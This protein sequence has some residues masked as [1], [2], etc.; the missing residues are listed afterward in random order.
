MEKS[1]QSLSQALGTSWLFAEGGSPEL[2]HSAF[3]SFHYEQ[4]CLRTFRTQKG[5]A[6]RSVVGRSQEQLFCLSQSPSANSSFFLA[7]ICMATDHGRDP[8]ESQPFTLPLGLIF[9]YASKQSSC[10]GHSGTS[11]K[12]LL[13]VRWLEKGCLALKLLL[14]IM[15][16][17][18]SYD[19]ACLLDEAKN[20][21]FPLCVQGE[22]G[23]VLGGV[24]VIPGRNGQPGPPVSII[25][26]VCWTLQPPK[27]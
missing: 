17:P 15:K 24:E 19:S 27:G 22:P 3:L 11:A 20:V 18:L 4:A 21:S 23:Y 26:K 8:A 6:S 9:F 25:P 1:V 16:L 14:H 5:K 12:V 13:Q 7:S 10:H 2:G